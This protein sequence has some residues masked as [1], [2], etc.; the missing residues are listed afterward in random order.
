MNMIDS[1]RKYFSKNLENFKTLS[2]V[3]SIKQERIMV[4]TC[5]ISLLYSNPK[6]F[7]K[8]IQD[9]MGKV[10]SKFFLLDIN[11]DPVS[12]DIINDYLA[13]ICKTHPPLQNMRANSAVSDIPV[14]EIHQTQLKLENL[15]TKV[16]VPRWYPY[17]ID[18]E[19]CPVFKCTPKVPSD[20]KTNIENLYFLSIFESFTYNFL[21]NS[22]QDK[23]TQI[24]LALGQIIAPCIA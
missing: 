14:I 6:N 21:F 11:G 18:C 19:M 15:D 1:L 13:S 2:L 12:A 8:C 20:F 17:Q 10:S 23:S 22:I 4:L 24:S 9:L 7:H 5:S 3:K 16:S